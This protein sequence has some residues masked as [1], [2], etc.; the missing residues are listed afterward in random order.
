MLK[1][2]RTLAVKTVE[3][4]FKAARWRAGQRQSV[5]CFRLIRLGL[6]VSFKTPRLSPPFSPP[7]RLLGTAGLQMR[8]TCHATQRGEAVDKSRLARRSRDLGTHSA[9]LRL[10]V[11]VV[12]ISALTACVMLN[13]SLPKHSRWFLSNRCRCRVYGVEERGGE[14]E[15]GSRGVQ[16]VCTCARSF[17]KHQIAEAPR[18]DQKQF[19]DTA[20]FIPK[21][22]KGLCLFSVHNG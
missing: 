13:A 16:C 2:D 6:F 4:S 22:P 12:A 20:S 14:P 19:F 5:F 7:G 21:T 11:A 10:N 8:D 1:F 9:A 18:R 3:Y 15:K 17:R